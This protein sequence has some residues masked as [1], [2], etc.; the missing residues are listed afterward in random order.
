MEIIL[1][2]KKLREEDSCKSFSIRIP[3]DLCDQLDAI[4]DEVCISRN[5]LIKI[6]LTE[7]IKSVKIQ[8]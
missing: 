2:R 8:D 6:L 3:S 7:S 1:S 4:A 5:E